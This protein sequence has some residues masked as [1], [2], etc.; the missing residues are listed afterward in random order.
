MNVNSTSA[1]AARAA[2]AFKA[3]ALSWLTSKEDACQLAGLQVG[4]ERG[5]GA[6]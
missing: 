6:V 5:A 2:T 4:E 1:D 3:V